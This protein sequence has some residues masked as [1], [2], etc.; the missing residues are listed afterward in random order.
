MT[1]RI[2]YH[3]EDRSI[4]L[5]L[6]K[7]FFIAP[8]LRFIPARVSPNAVTHLGHLLNLVAVVLLLTLQ[9][10]TGWPLVV[11]ALLVQLY[12]WCD[13]ADGGHARR[14]GQTSPFGE[15]LDHGLD[16]LNTAYIAYMSAYVL[17]AP[18]LWWVAMAMWVSA[19]VSLTYWEQAVT[20]VFRTGLVSQIESSFVLSIA[21]LISAALGISLWAKLSFFGFT[22]QVLFL[23]WMVAGCTVG[24]VRNIFRVAKFTGTLGS[25]LPVLPILAYGGLVSVAAASGAI[26]WWMAALLASAGNLFFSTRML[27]LRMNH[28]QPAVSR[29]LVFGCAV[30]AALIAWT[31]L[32]Q[33]PLAGTRIAVAVVVSSCVI[34]TIGVM[35]DVRRSVRSLGGSEHLADSPPAR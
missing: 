20:G 14:T 12:V 6:Y 10:K 26:A 24:F 4:L 34:F 13:N 28:G 3:A 18:G 8:T 5:P 21:M 15:L 17:E 29:T 30:L 23:L 7:R 19:A 16:I 1:D 33:Q 25:V 22:G 9:P 35:R 27:A 32:R 31:L 2:V 11:A